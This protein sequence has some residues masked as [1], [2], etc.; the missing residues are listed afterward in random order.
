MTA[1]FSGAVDD[2]K[3]KIAEI[4][5]LERKCVV[6]KDDLETCLKEKEHVAKVLKWIR[7]PDDP[8]PGHRQILSRTRLDLPEYYN[9]GRWFV[10][11]PEFQGW[12]DQI[13]NP[14]GDLKRLLWLRGTSMFLPD[15]SVKIVLT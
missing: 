6:H 12:M 15:L 11:S 3:L 14:A 5:R 10:E 1:A 9:A 4:K 7:A 13:E 2:W 8:E